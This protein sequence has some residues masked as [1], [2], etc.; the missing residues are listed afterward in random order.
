M[1][2]V[3]NIKCTH[4]VAQVSLGFYDAEGNLVR[5]EVFP[6]NQGALNVARLFYPHPEQLT[7]LIELCTEQAWAK[8]DAEAAAEAPAAG[9]DEAATPSPGKGAVQTGGLPTGDSA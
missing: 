8:L 7:A 6:Q 3:K 1:A 4:V 9:P 5:E 2:R